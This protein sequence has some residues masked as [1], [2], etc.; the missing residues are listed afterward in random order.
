MANNTITETNEPAGGKAPAKKRS[1][2]FFIILAVMVTGSL[3]LGITR[4][5]HSQKH[6]ETDDAQ[7]EANLSPVISKISG[8][9]SEVRIKDNQVVQKGDTLIVLDKRDLAMAV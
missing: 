4:Y 8:Y 6:E 9:I 7:V 1:P 3:Y 5:I 2:I